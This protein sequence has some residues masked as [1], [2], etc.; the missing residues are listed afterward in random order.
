M[1]VKNGENTYDIDI[2]KLKYWKLNRFQTKL[3]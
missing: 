1:N 3:K 2:I